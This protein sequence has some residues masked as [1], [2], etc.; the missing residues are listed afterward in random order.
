M[1]GGEL[2]VVDGGALQAIECFLGLVNVVTASAGQRG[3]VDRGLR[4]K[5]EAV[6]TGGC[7]G[8]RGTGCLRGER[9][10]VPGDLG[11]LDGRGTVHEWR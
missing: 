5:R 7:G 9:S 3:W 1:L 11:V 6:D 2:G 10:D 4:G 8:E